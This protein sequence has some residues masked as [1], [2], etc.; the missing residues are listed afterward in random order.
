M[1]IYARCLFGVAIVEHVGT[2]EQDVVVIG[3][4]EETTEPME[5]VKD[6][7]FRENRC[8]FVIDNHKWLK[9]K[10]GLAIHKGDHLNEHGYLQSSSSHD[11]KHVEQ[12]IKEIIVPLVITNGIRFDPKRGK[13]LEDT[14]TWDNGGKQFRL[15][16]ML[17][18]IEH[19]LRMPYDAHT[20]ACDMWHGVVSG[21]RQ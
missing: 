4:W 3:Q 9:P 19:I 2:H 20:H 1:H 13:V 21:N 12:W 11:M 18:N 16:A 17:K 5:A 14:T 10:M 6:C 8:H 7:F 15:F